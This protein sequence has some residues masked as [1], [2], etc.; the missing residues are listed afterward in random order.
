[1]NILL[2]LIPISLLLVGLALWSFFWAVDSGQFDDLDRPSLD[3]LSEDPLPTFMGP[4]PLGPAPMD[5]ARTE[6]EA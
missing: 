1:V 4:A 3:M 2:A 5:P 6:P